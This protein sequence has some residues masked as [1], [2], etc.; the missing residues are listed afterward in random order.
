MMLLCILATT[1]FAIADATTSSQQIGRHNYMVSDI[2]N[3]NMR[4]QLMQLGDTKRQ[5]SSCTITR[6]TTVKSLTEAL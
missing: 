1:A 6:V 2:P 3:G 4:R 5:V